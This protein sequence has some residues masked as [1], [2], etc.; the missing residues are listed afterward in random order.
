[1]LLLLTQLRVWDYKSIFVSARAICDV[2]G[3][4]IAEGFPVRLLPGDSYQAR[5]DR[6]RAVW[7]ACPYVNKDTTKKTSR[8]NRSVSVPSLS[9]PCIIR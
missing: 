1:M 2:H 4:V 9:P 7:D 8:D 5:Y 6:V 3:T